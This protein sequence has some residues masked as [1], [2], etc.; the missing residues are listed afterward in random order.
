MKIYKK[1]IVIILAILMATNTTIPIFAAE[2]DSAKEEIVYIMSNADGTVKN[3]NVV[4]IF[5]DG[6]ISDYG[7][8]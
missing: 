3:I 4:N 8:Y 6:N 5:D 7:D 1:V 2:N